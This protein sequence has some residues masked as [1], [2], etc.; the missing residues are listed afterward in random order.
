MTTFWKCHVMPGSHDN[1]VPNSWLGPRSTGWWLSGASWPAVSVRDWAW[2]ASPW[3]P[4]SRSPSACPRYCDRTL[5]WSAAVRVFAAGG[6]IRRAS[7]SSRC[8]YPDRSTHQRKC[9]WILLP[10]NPH[11]ETSLCSTVKPRP[12][13]CNMLHA[14]LLDHVATCW[15]GLAKRT[16]HGAWNN[17]AARCCTNM[18]HPFGQGFRQRRAE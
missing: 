1:H 3:R 9:V 2:A 6:R 4:S 13:G 5:F 10:G 17:V 16:Q 14:T 11:V 15:A 7:T 18:L 12:N 8:L